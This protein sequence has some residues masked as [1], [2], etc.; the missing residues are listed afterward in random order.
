MT[1]QSHCIKL[2]LEADR[3]LPVSG[4]LLGSRSFCK[5]AVKKD[6]QA[7]LG[8]QCPGH[9]LYCSEQLAVYMENAIAY[10]C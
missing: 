6:K 10:V 1:Q 7:K 4:R 5:A 8:L 2:T 9:I 3:L